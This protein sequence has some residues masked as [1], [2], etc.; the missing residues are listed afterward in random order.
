IPFLLYDLKVGRYQRFFISLLLLPEKS[1]KPESCFSLERFPKPFFFGLSSPFRE[2]PLR[3][4]PFLGLELRLRPSLGRAPAFSI[5]TSRP[6][7]STFL[8]PAYRLS[9]ILSSTS[10]KE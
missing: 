9:T 7:N 10:K 4:N 1:R 6:L 2:D 5:R 3:E 8:K